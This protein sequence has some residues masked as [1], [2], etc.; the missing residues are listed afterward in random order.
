[1]LTQLPEL[2]AEDNRAVALTRRGKPVLALMPWDLFQ[3]II[4]TLEIMGDAE[5]MAD[6]R[7]GIRD[8]QEGNLVAFDEVRT[9]FMRRRA[10]SIAPADIQPNENIFGLDQCPI[11]DRPH[12][13]SVWRNCRRDQPNCHCERSVAISLGEQRVFSQRDR[14]VAPVL[15]MTK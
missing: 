6:V 8:L 11:R 3:S 14:R 5:I 2:L 10:P 1:M 12:A 4:D 15:A 13:Y 9:E 7:R